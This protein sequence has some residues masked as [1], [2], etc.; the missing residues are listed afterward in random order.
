MVDAE[1]SPVV[2]RGYLHNDI[3]LNK[4]DSLTGPLPNKLFERKSYGGQFQEYLT[5]P[6]TVDSLYLIRESPISIKA[7]VLAI[8]QDQAEFN[9]S[10]SSGKNY[11]PKYQ[12]NEDCANPYGQRDYI[13]LSAVEVDEL[14][15]D[16]SISN[17][18]FP[19]AGAT[20]SITTTSTGQT[21]MDKKFS[22]TNAWLV[23]PIYTLT[24]YTSWIESKIDT[25]NDEEGYVEF[26]MQF[27]RPMREV[28][29]HFR[30]VHASPYQFLGDEHTEVLLSGGYELTY[31]SDTRILKDSDARS[32]DRYYRDGYGTVLIQASGSTFTE[33]IWRRLEDPETNKKKDSNW[34][35]FTEVDLCNDAD[36]DGVEDALDEFDQ[37]PSLAFTSSY[38]SSSTQAT[39]IFEDLWPYLGDYD[40]ND[41]A[42]DYQIT[43]Y[44]NAEDEIVKLDIEYVVTSDGAGFDNALAFAF[45]ELDPTQISSTTGQR[46]T[47]NVFTLSSSGVEEGQD[48]AVVPIFDNHSNELGLPNTIEIVFSS[49]IPKEQAG[50]A[51]FNPFLVVNGNREREIHLIGRSPTKLG[52]STLFVGGSNEDSD[53]DYK[54]GNGLPW[55][56][57]VVEAIP[58]LK[59]KRPID[60]GYNY[61]LVWAVS[62]GDY[63]KDWYKN[64][65]GYRNSEA[66]QN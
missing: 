65:N 55:A 29:M 28:L 45:P 41:T 8:E 12:K 60:E 42:L 49:P 31:N 14:G 19:K 62:G 13:D 25:Q 27:D 35:T 39:L 36:G 38:P 46:F 40:F 7:F 53:G 22:I 32:K 16:Y 1:D 6:V 24:G 11:D 17:I 57:N 63:F 34:F 5:V 33:I 59:E 20:A 30:S 56:I 4:L 26:R 64:V 66:L 61:F 52:N 2:Y 9:Y 43:E 37:D 50:S 54:T 23:S 15:A 44:L 21:E 58:M 51:P 10:D 48:Y 47:E 18:V 3:L